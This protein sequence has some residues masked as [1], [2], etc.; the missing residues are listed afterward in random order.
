MRAKP[1]AAAVALALLGWAIQANASTKVR[2]EVLTIQATNAGL[3]IDAALIAHA[4]ILRQAPFSAFNSFRLV[5]RQSYDMTVGSPTTLTL[6]ASLGGSLRLNGEDR[7]RLDLTLTIV[8]QGKSPVSIK[9]AASPGAPF[10]AAGFK[11][12]AG[13]W[14]FGVICSRIETVDH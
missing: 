4:A 2:C 9:G 13:T 5:H 1:L 10:F 14:V 12:Q 7:S 8:R 6:P 3:G 11:N